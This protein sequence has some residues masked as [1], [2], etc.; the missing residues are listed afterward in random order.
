MLFNVGRWYRLTALAR[1]KPRAAT[2]AAATPPRRQVTIAIAVLLALIFSKYFYLASLSSY[3]TFYLIDRSAFRCR[4]RSSTCSCS[5]PPSPRAP[6]WADRSAT[7]SAAS[8]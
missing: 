4:V 5:S 8:T 6:S 2:E 3:Y 1:L 7:A